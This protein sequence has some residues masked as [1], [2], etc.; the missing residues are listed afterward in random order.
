MP[1][2]PVLPEGPEKMELKSGRRRLGLDQRGQAPSIQPS[3]VTDVEKVARLSESRKSLDS[4][5]RESRSTL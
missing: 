4:L 2:L 1:R 5:S 3:N